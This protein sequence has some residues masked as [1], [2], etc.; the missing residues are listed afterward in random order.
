[1]SETILEKIRLDVSDI[2]LLKPEVVAKKLER[3][4]INK[5]DVPALQ[6]HL[7]KEALS[8]DV[9]S[10]YF[11]P[12]LKESMSELVKVL[13]TVRLA[14]YFNE[15]KPTIFCISDFSKISRNKVSPMIY[16][17]ELW[18]LVDT[19]THR[20]EQLVFPTATADLYIDVISGNLRDEY[21]N[22]D[23]MAELSKKNKL[24]RDD[25]AFLENLESAFRLGKSA[26]NPNTINYEIMD[27]LHEKSMKLLVE[28]KESTINIDDFTAFLN[29]IQQIMKIKD[30]AKKMS[31][32]PVELEKTNEK[33]GRAR[34]FRVKS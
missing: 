10:N 17:L 20:R 14:N 6:C 28:A 13:L 25:L 34:V 27:E 8:S 29:T 1:M 19:K 16:F 18:N 9:F 30:K 32:K 11:S 15:L 24:T 22:L 12:G 31:L 5:E 26:Y 2:V 21:R 33:L 7:A 23:K 3:G 4:G